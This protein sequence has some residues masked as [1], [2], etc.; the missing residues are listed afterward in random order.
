MG[1]ERGRERRGRIGVGGWRKERES[2]RAK[3]RD[4]HA[5]EFSVSACVDSEEV[6]AVC[7]VHK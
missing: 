1:V 5:T 4:V 7:E 6:A 2:K 3:E